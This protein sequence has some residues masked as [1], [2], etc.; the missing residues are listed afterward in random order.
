MQNRMP[1]QFANLDALTSA[2]AAA[3]AVRHG[4]SKGVTLANSTTYY[5]PIQGDMTSQAPLLGVALKWASAVVATITV[6]VSGFP[7]YPDGQHIGAEDVTDV[8][9]T[10]GDWHQINPSTAYVSVTGASNSVTALTITAGGAAAG[11]AWIDL[12]N[13]GAL[14]VRI[15]MV[16]TTGGL[17]RV[18]AVTK[19]I[20]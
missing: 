1:P 20:T 2:G 15:K 9:T 17:M 19:S 13:L 8:S 3:A 18:G 11:G 6:E 5:F 14:R 7:K 16:V 10:A 4:A 12:G